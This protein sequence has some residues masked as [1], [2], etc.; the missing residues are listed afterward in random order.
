MNNVLAVVIGV[1]PTFALDWTARAT[2]IDFEGWQRDPLG[3]STFRFYDGE[4]WTPY[5]SDGQ[6]TLTEGDGWAEAT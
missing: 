6:S 5:I 2:G 4:H 3:R 1:D